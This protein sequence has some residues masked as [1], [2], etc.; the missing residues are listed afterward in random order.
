MFLVTF[1]NPPH[2]DAPSSSE[3]KA[4]GSRRS[5]T[6]TK[7]VRSNHARGASVR[8]EITAPPATP[9]GESEVLHFPMPL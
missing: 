5:L 8:R 6:L 7:M 3:A 9:H 4:A 1:T 2:G